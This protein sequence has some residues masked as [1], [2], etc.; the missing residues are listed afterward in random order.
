MDLIK[1][2]IDPDLLTKLV[3]YAIIAGACVVKVPQIVNVLRAGNAKGL[4][5]SAIYLETV[6]TLAGT[7]YNLLMGNAFR[8]YGETALILA[9]NLIIVLLV[10]STTLKPGS[11]YMLF[12]TSAFVGIGAALWNVQQLD[13]SWPSQLKSVG[14]SPLDTVQGFMTL[15]Y[16]VARVRRRASCSLAK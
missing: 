7:I 6:A 5:L 12:V 3:S 14:V 8:T 9:Q 11:S 4:S 16:I 2:F 1:R 15:L 10:W 13:A